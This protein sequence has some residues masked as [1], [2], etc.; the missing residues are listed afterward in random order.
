MPQNDPRA[1]YVILNE[2][3]MRITVAETIPI[4]Y[5]TSATVST[6]EGSSGIKNLSFVARRSTLPGALSV[7]GNFVAG[8][9]V[10]ADF[11]NGLPGN[12]TWL[13]ADGSDTATVDIAIKGDGDFEANETFGFVLQPGAGYR[14]G[15]QTSITGTIVNDDSEVVQAEFQ[16]T[17]LATAD[18]IYQRDTD[19]GG[20]A[21]K[22][23]GRIPIT[24][25]VTK[26]GAIFARLRN[27]SG[28]AIIQD[29]FLAVANAPIAN[30]PVTLTGI[31]ARLGWFY[32]DIQNPDGSW[33]QGTTAVGMGGNTMMGSAQSLG[34]RMF[35][36]RAGSTIAQLGLTPPE[37][38]RCYATWG[39]ENDD[40]NNPVWTKPDTG[41]LYDSAGA[42]QYLNRMIALTGV[43]HGFGGHP[44]GGAPTGAF[45]V[46]GSQASRMNAIAE[47]IGGF[48]YY[49]TFIGHTDSSQGTPAYITNTNLSGAMDQCVARNSRGRNFRTVSLSIPTN[50]GA[51]QWGTPEQK[52][53]VRRTIYDW[54]RRDAAGDCTGGAVY[55]QTGAAELYDQV[56]Q[57]N[58][59][60][61][62]LANATVD[63]LI[64]GSNTGDG[65]LVG[66]SVIP[67]VSS[68]PA[69][70]TYLAGKNFAQALEHDSIQFDGCK[71]GGAGVVSV[72]MKVY[73]TAYQGG[74]MAFADNLGYVYVRANGAVAWRFG[75]D[76][77]AGV[78]PLNKWFDFVLTEIIA[79]PINGTS[80]LIQIWVDG[81]KVIEWTDNDLS[82]DQR[83]FKIGGKASMRQYNADT[84]NYQWD[85]GVRM[86]EAC[87]FNKQI[88]GIIP[89]GMTGQ[90]PRLMAYAPLN[91]N[92]NT[93]R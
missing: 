93:L 38:G 69:T 74:R 3:D 4:V 60:A 24:L 1:V 14:L 68:A 72:G 34:L 83:D 64:N 85:T 82:G 9:A 70:K 6:T 23:L 15:A 5:F 8:T 81:V 58:T 52:D 67:I 75:P 78:M 51:N 62:T 86:A 76:S 87:V 66:T 77:A 53:Y 11:P 30:G 65:S 18:R 25:N 49:M 88:N 21:G 39:G 27:A 17:Q 48:E 20:P 16:M 36:S 80:S 79:D 40:M 89:D 43:N 90:E 10:A 71:N 47:A 31:G 26:A 59:G 2:M 7:L 50:T 29:R 13:F 84:T 45:A 37:F 22:G 19:T 54:A 91:G 32:V 12:Q 44:V 56:H 35:K 63:A 73:L 41:A 46:L 61:V 55:A 28:G 33:T 57:S 92:L 42:V